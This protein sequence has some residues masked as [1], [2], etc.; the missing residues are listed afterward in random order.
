M[1]QT[2]FTAD[3][4]KKLPL[5]AIVALA[6]RCAR[7]V[8]HLALPE[9]ASREEGPGLMIADGL[10][11]AEDFALGRPSPT[12]ETAVQ[13]IEVGL[14]AGQGEIIGENARAAVVRAIHA[15]ATA[16]RAVAEREEPPEKRLLSGGPLEQ[17]MSHLADVS[18]DLAAMG[19]FTA[20]MDAAEAYRTTDDITKWAARDY[21]KLLELK[22][23]QFPEAG[24]PIDPSPE[25]PLGPLRTEESPGT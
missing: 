1:S 2:S 18:A 24:E 25:G 8:T 14:P 3:D 19:A 4:L 5:R 16:A 21:R 22:L 17:P 10:R 15:A 11:A 6:V 13:A 7:R 23:G 12:L 9:D 20:A